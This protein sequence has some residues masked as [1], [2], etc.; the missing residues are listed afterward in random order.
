MPREGISRDDGQQLSH[1]LRIFDLLQLPEVVERVVGDDLLDNLEAFFRVDS[2]RDE[3]E[4]IDDQIFYL[5]GLAESA[6]I[7]NHSG[8]DG[9]ELPKQVI[10]QFRV[11]IILNNSLITVLLEYILV[12]FILRSH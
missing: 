4:E 1:Y 7:D 3:L 5:I 10:S 6:V 2:N 12:L 9:E 8:S 11:Q